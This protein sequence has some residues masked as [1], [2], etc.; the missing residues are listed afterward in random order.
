MIHETHNAHPE[1]TIVAYSDNAAVFEG[2][3]VDRLY[4]R[5]NESALGGREY[6][7]ESEPTHT[8]FKVE[9]HNHPTAISPFLEPL[10]VPAARFVTKEPPA[11]VHVRKQV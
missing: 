2:S 10:P 4:P 6:S 3:E 5:G 9:T 11:A 1:G 8:V 7:Y